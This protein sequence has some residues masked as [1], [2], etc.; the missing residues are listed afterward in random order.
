MKRKQVSGKPDRAKKR[1]G[2]PTLREAELLT[3]Q[4]L[5]AATNIFLEQGFVRATVDDI[6]LKAGITKQ[7][8]Y[9]RFASKN[10]LF[11][12]LVNRL[13][14]MLFEP[15]DVPQ[16]I[17][18]AP[19]TVLLQFAM[20]VVSKLR[21]PAAQRLFAVVAAESREFPELVSRFWQDGP[22]RFR[23]RLRAYLD[24]QVARKAMNI[25]DIDF[26]VEQ[27]VSLLSGPLVARIVLKR[28]GFFDSDDQEK[29]WVASAVQIFLWIYSI[30]NVRKKRVRVS[31]RA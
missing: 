10:A 7:T 16:D 8:V 22:G 29:R 4:I 25:P 17:D 13:V 1:L 20:E 14:T 28:P 24:E 31:R 23:V 2:R 6:A 27:M 12:A 26:A 15:T 5:E 18:G 3:E 21:E 19:R 9:A 30:E 11:E